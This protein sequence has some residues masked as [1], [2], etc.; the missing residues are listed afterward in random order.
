[1][2]RKW[3]GL[4]I[5]L[6]SKSINDYYCKRRVKRKEDQTEKRNGKTEHVDDRVKNPAKAAT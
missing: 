3:I 4:I 2:Q 1:M 6:K 5:T